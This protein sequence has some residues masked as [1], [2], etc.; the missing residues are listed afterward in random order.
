MTNEDVGTPQIACDVQ[1]YLTTLARPGGMRQVAAVIGPWLERHGCNPAH[2]RYV[3]GDVRACEL[4]LRFGNVAGA[5]MEIRTLRTSDVDVLHRFGAALSDRSKDLFAPYPWNNA[6]GL[7]RAFA[8]AVENAVRGK[9]L[10]FLVLCGEEPIGHFFLWS[11]GENAHARAHGVDIPE[12][13]V[14]IADAYHRCGLGFLAVRL[15]QVMASGMGKDAI[16]LTTAVSN[17]A[18]WSTYQRAGFVFTGMI[19]NPLDVDVT[20]A[21]EGAVR[22]SRYREERQMVYI[23]QQDR[24]GDVQRYLERKRALF[25]GR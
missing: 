9:D 14:A 25:A 7:T 23:L 18:G 4:S 13:G 12:L 16:E 15:L 2:V 20:A 11:A 8:T 10:A 1:T 6:D 22:P 17:D 21:V 3:V 5:S 19:R 24:Q